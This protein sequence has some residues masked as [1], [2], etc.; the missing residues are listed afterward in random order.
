MGWALTFIGSNKAQGLSH[1]EIKSALCI[2]MYT[3]VW[4]P[5]QILN[6]ESRSFYNVSKK[7]ETKL[8]LINNF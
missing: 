1:S 3:K 8:Q 7:L 6:H 5:E 2:F 4:L